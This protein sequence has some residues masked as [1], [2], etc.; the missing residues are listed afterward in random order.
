M[1]DAQTEQTAT[2]AL[3]IAIILGALL[4]SAAIYLS[5]GG[6]TQAIVSK[7]FEVKVENAAP[8]AQQPSAQ[9]PTQAAPTQA[10]PT[11]SAP[12]KVNVD[13]SG[14]IA[15]GKADAPV[16]I[17]EFS[18]FECPF[19]GRAQPTVKQIEQTYGDKVKLVFMH[20]PLPFH[21]SAQKAAEASECA[22]DQGKFW[23]MHDKMFDNQ[24]ALSV[25]QL[26]GYAKDLGLNT[27]QFN[28]CLDSGSKAKAISADMAKGQAAGVE[29]TPTFIINGVPVVGAQPYSAFSSVIDAALKQ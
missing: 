11:P 21:A 13:I 17:V 5:V 24:Q 6:L 4:L 20:Y 3:G 18:D 19:C 7:N 29:G 16:T 25:D 22:L 28:T 10:A 1:A 12:Q 9:Q 15:R 8:A 26:K 23:E 14:K 27:T 2:Y